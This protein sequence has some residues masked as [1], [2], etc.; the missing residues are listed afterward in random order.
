VYLRG[1]VAGDHRRELV[2]DVARDAAPELSVRTE[3]AVTRVRPAADGTP[4]T[5]A[6]GGQEPGA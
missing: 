1:E 4:L 6:P 2:A 3:V 5:E